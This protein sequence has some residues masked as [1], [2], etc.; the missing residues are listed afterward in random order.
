MV[1]WFHVYE[2]HDG[3]LELVIRTFQT[4]FPNFEIWDV[5]GGDLILVGSQRPWDSS[6]EKLRRSYERNEARSELASI[7]LG[8]PETLLARQFASQRTAFAIAG[9]GPIQSDQFPVLEYE[10]PLAF[11]IGANATRIMRFDE[12]TWQSPLA[13]Q[14]KRRTLAGLNNDTLRAAFTN[15]TINPELRLAIAHR[16]Q[17]KPGEISRPPTLTMADVPCLFD[18]RNGAGEA[19]FAEN[20]SEDLKSLLSA[21]AA[22]QQDSED[23]TGH[24]E[25][26]HRIVSAQLANAGGKP[27]DRRSS[28]FAGVAA[29]ACIVH[30]QFGLAGELLVMGLRIVPGEPELVYLARLLEREQREKETARDSANALSKY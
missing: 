23:W 26:I 15:S 2:M 24:V 27:L 28:H 6:L 5:N 13:A 30:H 11:F 14:D 20:T 17:H 18:S 16:L 25:T 3:I 29:R 9:T 22:L 1:Q 8:T 7:G 4:V 19:Q 10:A 12:R 21:R